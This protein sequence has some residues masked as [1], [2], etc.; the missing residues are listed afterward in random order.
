MARD[1]KKAAAASNGGGT[2]AAAAAA[3][4]PLSKPSP[5]PPPAPKKAPAAS[6]APH[7]APPSPPSSNS[8]AAARVLYLPPGRYVLKKKIDVRATNLVL[9]GA[10]AA[11]TTIFIPLSLT[12]AY[13]NTFREGGGCCASDYSHGTGFLNFWGWDSINPWNEI[14]RVTL[15]AKRG[16][17]RLYVDSTS[18]APPGGGK[19]AS[20]GAPLSLEGALRAGAPVR[21]AMDGDVPA[22]LSDLKG[23][24]FSPTEGEVKSNAAGKV[25]RLLTRV[26]AVGRD[27]ELG[28]YVELERPLQSNVSLAFRPR[29]HAHEPTA[30]GVGVEDLTVEFAWAPYAG[31]LKEAGYNAIHFNQVADGWVRDVT[32]VNSD[33]GVYLWGAQSCAVDNVRIATT[34]P[35]GNASDPTIGNQNGHRGVWLEHGA[36]NLVRGLRVESPF[37]HDVTVSWTEQGT[38]VAASSGADLNIDHHRTAPFGNLYTDL[39][40][41]RGNRPLESSGDAR[42]GPHSAAW[43]TY[44]NTRGELP[45]AYPPLVGGRSTPGWFAPL[46]TF[47][48]F[49]A[50]ASS[51]PPAGPGAMGWWT[52]RTSPRAWPEDLHAHM[53]ASREARWAALRAREGRRQQREEEGGGGGAGSAARVPSEAA[54][55]AAEAQKAKGAAVAKAAAAAAEQERK[56]KE[57]DAVSAALKQARAA[58]EAE[59]KKKKDAAAKAAAAAAAAEEAKKTAAKKAP[60]APRAPEQAAAPVK[61]T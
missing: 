24:F 18:A 45:F 56:K 9:R 41:G 6:A 50:A 25:V 29:F 53:R 22:L 40:H 34:R 26:A 5:P 36:D 59:K 46:A 43:P 37:T 10:G 4:A 2:A 3:A 49:R 31:H 8:S 35:R 39:A 13:G 52:E 48:G 14:A 30:A 42:N 28:P 23:G 38:V 27:P 16:D 32:I 11:R 15:P 60:P 20:A 47:V 44:W 61:K 1:A 54:T 51:E 12:E 33:A 57:R 55:E 58:E 7:K 19:P 21:F 17:T